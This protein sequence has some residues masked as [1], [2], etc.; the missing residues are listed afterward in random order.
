MD[1]REVFTIDG[2]RFSNMAGFYYEVERLFTFGLDWRIGLN[3][4]AF[5]DMLRGGFVRHV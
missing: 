3:L 2:S 4:N 5:S 1:I